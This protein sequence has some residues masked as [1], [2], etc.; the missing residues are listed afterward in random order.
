MQERLGRDKDT[1]LC[2]RGVI[3]EKSFT[4]FNTQHT[5]YV[6]TTTAAIKNLLL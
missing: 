2:V 1:S 4:T 3:D 5:T 6:L